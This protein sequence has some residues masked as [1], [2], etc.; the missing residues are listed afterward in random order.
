MMCDL[1]EEALFNPLKAW[2]MAKD[3]ELPNWLR[4]FAE[5]ITSDDLNPNLRQ[6]IE[7]CIKN[8]NEAKK[9]NSISFDTNRSPWLNK[10]IQILA[11][12]E[13]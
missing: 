3:E 7:S 1:I 11:A 6:T 9:I 12:R 4:L 2:R 8:T 10:V 13:N 5:S